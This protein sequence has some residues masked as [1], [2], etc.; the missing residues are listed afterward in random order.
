MPSRLHDNECRDARAKDGCLCKLHASRAPRTAVSRKRGH[1][2]QRGERRYEGVAE[3]G[4][5]E[6]CW[7]RDCAPALL[8][9]LSSCPSLVTQPTPAFGCAG[10]FSVGAAAARC[11]MSVPAVGANLTM[12]PRRPGHLVRSPPWC[13]IAKGGL[14]TPP[15]ACVQGDSAETYISGN[16]HDMQVLNYMKLPE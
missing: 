1:T 10:A 13:L 14:R 12:H 6:W 15:D 11:P 4:I 2:P 16:L 7:V 3:R 9:P 5:L 8:K